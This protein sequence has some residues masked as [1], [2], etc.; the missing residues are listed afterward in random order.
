MLL[1][2]RCGQCVVLLELLVRGGLTSRAVVASVSQLTE[3]DLGISNQLLTVLGT[4]LGTRAKIR[5]SLL[6]IPA[7]VSLFRSAH[8]PHM[9]GTSPHNANSWR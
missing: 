6:F 8:H 7:Q 9:N 5:P 1:L 3:T 2:R 4:V